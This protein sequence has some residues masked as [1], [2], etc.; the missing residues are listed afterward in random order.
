MLKY[1]L[2]IMFSGLYIA[3]SAGLSDVGQ[4]PLSKMSVYY[5]SM[6]RMLRVFLYSMCAAYN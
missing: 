6:L 2:K 1:I 5:E 3:A 4:A